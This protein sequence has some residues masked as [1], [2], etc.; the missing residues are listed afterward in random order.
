MP[1]RT[2]P[3]AWLTSLALAAALLVPPPARA[4]LARTKNQRVFL[5]SASDEVVA[6]GAKDLFREPFRLETHTGCAAVHFSGEI[7]GSNKD[8]DPHVLASFELAVDDTPVRAPIFH[9]APTIALPRIVSIDGYA[10]GL[11]WGSHE[12]S[13]RVRAE[14]LDEVTVGARVLELRVGA[15]REV[16]GTIGL[17]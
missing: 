7:R 3:A 10:C 14:G 4:E 17:R 11:S 5:A 16:L 6:G 9:E 15:G 13:V 8:V 12:V 2:R 1:F